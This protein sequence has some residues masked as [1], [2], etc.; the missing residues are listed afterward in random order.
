MKEDGR[1]ENLNMKE[2]V[3]DKQVAEEENNSYE[4]I[5]RFDKG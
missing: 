1:R 3:K 2:E 4:S 5:I